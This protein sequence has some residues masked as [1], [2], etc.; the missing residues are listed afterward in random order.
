MFKKSLFILSLI[1]AT[2]VGLTPAAYADIY[3]QSQIEQ[4]TPIESPQTQND[5][6]GQHVSYL[7]EQ[8]AH[9]KY[10]I[11]DK[12]QKLNAIHRLEDHASKLTNA[13][14]QNA[15]VKI[16]EAIIL[17]TDAGIVKGLSALGKVEKAKELLEQSLKI[18][19]NALDGSA[20]TSLGSLYYQVPG[21]PI[22]FGDDEKAELNLKK[23]LQINPDGID[24]NFFY[25]DFLLKDGRYDLA[26]RHLE[27][28]LQAAPRLHRPIADAGSIEEIKAALAKIAE[29][30]KDG[31]TKTV[32]Y[33]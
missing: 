26:R 33:N 30:S 3:G 5:I 17:S 23:A 20:Y 15:D 7:Q 31:D 10:Q 6:V 28:A 12:E 4:T 18:N 14:P 16:W 9:I 27:R 11:Q 19:P 25:G 32:K 29:K 2:S 1:T 13:Y 22:A 21:W 8:W 24:P